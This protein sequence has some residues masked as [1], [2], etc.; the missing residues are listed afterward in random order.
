MSSRDTQYGF[1]WE[2]ITVER[3]ASNTKKP[4]FKVIR[5]WTM[6]G[7]VVDI[8]MRPRSTEV[9]KHKPEVSK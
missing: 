8:V 6:N 2:D 4:K 9:L 3:V 7:E 5:V 1:I